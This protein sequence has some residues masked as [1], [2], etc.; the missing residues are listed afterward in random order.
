MATGKERRSSP[1][2]ARRPRSRSG[3]CSAGPSAP[4]GVRPI[5]LASSPAT[6]RRSGSSKPCSTRYELR[7]ARVRHGDS[8]AGGGPLG[9]AWAWLTGANPTGPLWLAL[10]LGVLE[11]LILTAGIVVALRSLDGGAAGR[12]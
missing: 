2:A 10:G 1:T 12:K 3:G 9:A 8:R 6:R 5:R 4:R 7:V 11:L